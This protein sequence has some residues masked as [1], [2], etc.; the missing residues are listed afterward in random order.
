[1]ISASLPIAVAEHI[2]ITPSLAY[3]FALSDDASDEME[4]R[5]T[6][7]DDDSFIY[8]GVTVSMAF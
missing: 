4:W 6:K 3:T 8:G 7:G 5:S 2:T 1:V